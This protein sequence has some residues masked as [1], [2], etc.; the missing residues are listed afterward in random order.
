M[1]LVM[2]VQNSKGQKIK[3]QKGKIQKLLRQISKFKA[4]NWLCLIKT[5]VKILQRLAFEF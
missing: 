2:K 1:G 4:F 3:I 5:K